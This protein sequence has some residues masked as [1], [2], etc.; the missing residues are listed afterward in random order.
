MAEA[1]SEVAPGEVAIDEV[2]PIQEGEEFGL[3]LMDADLG[4]R[5]AEEPDDLNRTRKCIDAGPVV[6]GGD[7]AGG[8]ASGPCGLRGAVPQTPPVVRAPPRRP[9][10]AP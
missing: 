7:L 9:W 3:I 1:P 10:L 5:W 2:V 8:L 4:Q 6:H